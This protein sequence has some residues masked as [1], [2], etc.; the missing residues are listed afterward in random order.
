MHAIQDGEQK[1]TSE[2]VK[3]LF[4][5][6]FQDYRSIMTTKT[7]SI[8]QSSIYFSFLG[9]IKSKIEFWIKCRIICKVVY[10][11]WNNVLRYSKY[12]SQRLDYPSRSKA[13]ACH[14]FGRTD[15]EVMSTFAKNIQD[16]FCF[17]Y[18]TQRS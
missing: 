7:K 2:A 10:C 3:D 11:R 18:I 5:V 17:S 16:R 1:L 13:M 8:T 6:L 15:I 14:R 4:F 9:F 12:T